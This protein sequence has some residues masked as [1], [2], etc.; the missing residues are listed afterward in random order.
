MAI[1]GKR[2]IMYQVSLLQALTQGDYYGSVPVRELKTKGDTGLGTF[3]RLN[4]EMI[5]LDGKVYRADGEGKVA[6]VLDDET[7]PFASVAYFDEEEK[8]A[9]R[10]V[11]DLN[12][13]VSQ[14]GGMYTEDHRNY[15]QLVKVTGTFDKM[16]VRSVPAQKAPYRPLTEVMETDQRLFEYSDISGTAVGVYC[17]VYMSSMNCAGW[18]FHFI[19]DDKSKGGHILDLAINEGE[20]QWARAEAV[21]VDLPDEEM[22]GSC[23][24]TIDRSGDVKKIESR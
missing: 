2:R 23:D 1:K 15:F 7:T 14:L 20:V 5:M 11:D 18:H 10:S 16:L 17:P 9:L 12:E 6:E 21:H 13:L 4:G 3:D 22:F 19:S 8:A 24:F